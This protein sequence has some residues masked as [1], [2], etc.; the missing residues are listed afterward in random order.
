MSIREKIDA[1]NKICEG[2]INTTD[3]EFTELT[4]YEKFVIGETIFYY[5]VHVT[6][7][8][9]HNR[10]T[11]M[12]SVEKFCFNTST[13]DANKIKEHSQKLVSQILFLFGG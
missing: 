9:L 3:M 8:V 1:L 12:N 11:N 10:L 13:C 4:E 2:K 7:G 6:Q 5:G